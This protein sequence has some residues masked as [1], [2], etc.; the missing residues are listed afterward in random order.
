MLTTVAGDADSHE[1]LVLRLYTYE[2]NA[3]YAVSNDQCHQLLFIR[4]LRHPFANFPVD[5]ANKKYR[6]N[7]NK[8]IFKRQNDLHAYYA[9][10]S[11]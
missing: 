4:Y 5:S 10:L 9:H 8:Q 6:W 1:C 3:S 11:S 7:S 2:E